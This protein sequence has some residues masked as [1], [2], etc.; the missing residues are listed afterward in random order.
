MKA[1][2]DTGHKRE[3]KWTKWIIACR[4]ADDSPLNR[5]YLLVISQLGIS[6]MENEENLQTFIDL[7]LRIILSNYEY[8]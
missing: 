2:S 6:K 3:T 8:C 4:S 1:S 7:P 5:K